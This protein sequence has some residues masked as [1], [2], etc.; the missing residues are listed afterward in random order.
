MRHREGDECFRCRCVRVCSHTRRPYDPYRSYAACCPAL[1]A[2]RIPFVGCDGRFARG[3]ALAGGV[4][5]CPGKPFCLS[6]AFVLLTT[7]YRRDSLCHSGPPWRR[8]MIPPRVTLTRGVRTPLCLIY[9]Q[10]SGKVREEFSFVW[11]CFLEFGVLEF[12]SL[13]FG[14]W[15]LF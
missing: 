12:W 13:A 6:H 2:G 9:N 3:R 5:C 11:V 1:R 10:A 14:V 8:R 4:G 7:C 15:R